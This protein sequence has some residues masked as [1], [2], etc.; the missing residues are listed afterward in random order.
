VKVAEGLGLARFDLKYSA[1]SLPHDKMLRSI[2]LY[3]DKVAPMVRAELAA[4][5]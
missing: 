2:E 3:G 4:R 1:G 5:S